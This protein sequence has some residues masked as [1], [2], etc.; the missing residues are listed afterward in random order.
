MKIST[1]SLLSL[2]YSVAWLL[3]L[4][5]APGIGAEPL[6][7]W[8][9]R[10]PAPT[11]NRLS[12]VAYGNGL[13]VAVGDFG[14]IETSSD[15]VTWTFRHAEAATLNGVA[16]GNDRFVAVGSDGLI[17]N[18]QDGINW[19]NGISLSSSWLIGV[20]YGNGA[21]VAAGL[22]GS[23][24][25]SSN[26]VN[27]TDGGSLPSSLRTITFGNGRF[28]VSAALPATIFSENFDNVSAPN[29]PPGWTTSLTGAAMAW[30][31]ANDLSD[32][33][34]NSVFASDPSSTS[35]NQLTSPVIP[36]LTPSAQ[37]SFSHTYSTGDFADYCSL[38]LSMN[39]GAFADIHAVGGSFVSNGYSG[40]GWT[41]NSFGW[42]QT[43]VNLPASA[44][45]QT[46]QIRW[47]LRSN[48][49]FGGAGW[50]IDT[51]AVREPI[52]RVYTS[53]DL[54]NWIVAYNSDATLNAFAHGNNTFV[55]VGD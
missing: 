11:A 41:G 45:G 40:A 15:G 8:H 19:A 38:E 37:L 49:F 33:S 54:V 42:S 47:R 4:D 46:I 51:I 25:I 7:N 13:F 22:E 35:D 5:M 16:F 27:W 3:V 24:L 26:G 44:A 28:V 2:I 55:A 34:P 21:F 12:A 30:R 1:R 23:L 43:I 48:A 6:E 9:W 50:H 18:S 52:A 36:I 14:T 53:T 20:A 39:G 31:T 10:N 29:L 17:L 32:T